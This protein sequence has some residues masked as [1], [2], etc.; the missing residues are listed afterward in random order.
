MPHE[1]VGPEA[2]LVLPRES[3]D[4]VCAWICSMC[5]RCDGVPVSVRCL[6]L[7]SRLLFWV[8]GMTTGDVHDFHRG[9]WDVLTSSQIV[10][11]SEDEE[12]VASIDITIPVH[13]HYAAVVVPLRKYRLVSTP[14]NQPRPVLIYFH[15]G[16]FCIQ[17]ERSKSS[18]DL[19]RTLVK[20]LGCDA[21]NVGYRLAPEHPFP[22]GLRDAYAALRYVHALTEH[23]GAPLILAGD[24]AGGNF[25]LVLALCARDEI[26]ADGRPA[27]GGA[28]TLLSR[29]RHLCLLYPAMNE[30]TPS[31][32]SLQM[33]YLMPR[34]MRTLY[35]HSYLGP[36]EGLHATLQRDWRIA[37]L[38]SPSLGGLPPVS[39]VSC[40]MDPLVDED[41]MLVAA[42]QRAGNPSVDCIHV[43]GA[44]HGF[45]TLPSFAT[46][47][48]QCANV[49]DR[50]EAAVKRSVQVRRGTSMDTG[51]I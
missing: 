44:I 42:L 1:G 9:M 35:K 32:R 11:A 38:R 26:D 25:A 28:P 18:H 40:G 13:A 17:S 20:R 30:I 29:I 24:S 36:D 21:Y 51:L 4:E 34:G 27:A 37:P 16:G 14:S 6:D 19:V 12:G 23:A 46:S 22:H 47:H 5:F 3:C 15:G 48:A 43:E 33:R 31:Q 7:I 8:S 39:V 50:L 49:L 41:R 2:D 10:P 45:L